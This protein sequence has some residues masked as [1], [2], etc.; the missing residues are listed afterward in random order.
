MYLQN[1]SLTNR[2]NTRT[3]GEDRKYSFPL[4]LPSP[5]GDDDWRA[6]EN[7]R[8]YVAFYAENESIRRNKTTV[9]VLKSSANNYDIMFSVRSL[10]APYGAELKKYKQNKP[11]GRIPVFRPAAD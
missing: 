7:G 4:V 3:P 8:I 1:I 9:R 5:A 10:F 6:W 11:T 2:N